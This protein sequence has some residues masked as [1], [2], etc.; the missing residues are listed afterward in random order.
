M[1]AAPY[2]LQQQFQEPI[3][4]AESARAGMWVFIATEVMFFGGLILAY[5]VGRLWYPQAFAAASAKLNLVAGTFNTVI[6][7]GS[8]FVF[9][10]AMQAFGRGA[11]LTTIWW[12]AVTWFLGAVFLGTKG[13]EYLSEWREHLVPGAHFALPG[14][15]QGQAQLFFF[16]YFVMTGLHAVHLLIG[17]GV[18]FVLTVWILVRRSVA[19][20]PMPVEIAALYWHFVDVVWIILFTLL[21]LSRHA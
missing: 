7:V 9:L 6:L 8:S 3:Q 16:F 17:L 10:L 12:L 13:Y 18:I 21:Y 11:R 15:D 19:G 2:P 14:V 5:S 20:N 4:Q 1:K